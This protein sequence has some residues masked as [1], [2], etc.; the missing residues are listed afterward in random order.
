MSRMLVQ[1]RIEQLLVG[2][3]DYDGREWDDSAQQ[4]PANHPQEAR[5]GKP[6]AMEEINPTAARLACT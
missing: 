3:Q 2:R 5:P 4:E 1:R 6:C